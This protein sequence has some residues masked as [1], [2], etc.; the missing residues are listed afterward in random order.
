MFIEPSLCATHLFKHFT[1]IGS[2]VLMITM[3]RAQ[4]LVHFEMKDLRSGGVT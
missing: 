1:Y 2:F 3:K 4:L